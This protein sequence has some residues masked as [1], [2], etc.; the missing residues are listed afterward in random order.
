MSLS[1]PVSSTETVCV[2]CYKSTAYKDLHT[3]K[4]VAAQ[5]LEDRQ[6]QP[7]WVHHVCSYSGQ[8]AHTGRA[9]TSGHRS[10]SCLVCLERYTLMLCWY[11]IIYYI[12]FRF[13]SNSL[14]LFPPLALRA[15]QA[16]HLHHGHP[17]HD[18]HGGVHWG[19]D[20]QTT[21]SSGSCTLPSYSR[22][23]YAET[24]TDDPLTYAIYSCLF[25]FSVP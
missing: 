22:N 17:Q 20:H 8:H 25:P 4:P 21:G 10:L 12:I 3:Q 23:T 19:D 11:F 14:L 2:L 9:G 6:L 16:V 24:S 1:A 15:V 5:I 18:L 7:V 13:S